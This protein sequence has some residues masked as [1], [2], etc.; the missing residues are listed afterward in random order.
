[1]PAIPKPR[2]RKVE[3]RRQRAAE[4]A[5]VKI[6]RSDVVA[7]D[8]GCRACRGLGRKPSRVFPL[9][10]HELVY[11]SQTRGLPIEERVNTQNCVLLCERCH[12]DLHAKRL[13]VHITHDHK[14]ADGQLIFK[15]F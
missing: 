6:V 4:A 15:R 14:G 2:P 5:W 8:R 12:R 10:M 1:M 9:Q 7:R 13:A 11:R 3:R